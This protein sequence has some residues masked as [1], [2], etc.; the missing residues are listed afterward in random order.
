[1]PEPSVLLISILRDSHRNLSCLS[2][3]SALKAASIDVKLLFVPR[4]DEYNSE[5]LRELLN[6]EAFSVVGISLMTDGMDFSRRLTSDIK[7]FLDRAHI[8]WGGIHPT[9]MPQECLEYADSVCIGEG[10]VAFLKL[11]QCFFTGRDI[12]SIPGIGLKTKEGKCIINP[13]QLNSDL[14]SIAFPRYG[15]SDFYVIDRFGLRRFSQEEYVRYSNYR[16]EDYTLMAT[17][18]CPFSCSYCCNSYLNSLYKEGN[19][20]RKRS[21]GHV[22]AEIKYALEY[23]PNIK[24]VN[25]IDDQFLTSRQWNDEFIERYTKEV[26]L[27]F[28]VRL[29]PGSFDDGVLKKLKD[30]GLMFTQ[31]GIQSGSSRTHRLIYHRSFNKSAVVGSSRILSRNQVYPYYDIIIQN[32]LEEDRDRNQ[33]IKLLLKIARPFSLTLYAL[34]AY[35]RTELEEIYKQRGVVPRTNPYERGYSDYDESDFY[36]QLASVIPYTALWLSKLFFYFRGV[37][38]VK[39]LLEFYYKRTPKLRGRNVT[40]QSIAARKK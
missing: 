22:I 8:T 4:Q 34:T 23:I 10:E 36:Y 14:D 16:G 9:L 12:S 28:I 5:Q 33:T 17:R 1:M 21:V 18:G 7:K 29:V 24:F 20:I 15:W 6:A 31:I 35:P 38:G 3:Y 37:P 19:R 13:P 25:F 2:L 30:A 27:P 40:A 11:L 32:D 39:K 26:G